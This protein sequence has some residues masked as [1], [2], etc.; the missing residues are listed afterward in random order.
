LFFSGGQSRFNNLKYINQIQ[1]VK[2]DQSEDALFPHKLFSPFLS[3]I[4]GSVNLTSPLTGSKRLFLLPQL[5]SNIVTIIN[6]KTTEK[7]NTKN[8]FNL[9]YYD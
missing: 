8:F 6:I 4:L 2:R 9:S 5:L 1:K 7:A 3:L